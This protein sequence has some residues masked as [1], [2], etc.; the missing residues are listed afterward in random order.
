M[1]SNKKQKLFMSAYEHCH[2]PFM[3]YCSALAF[4]KMD[5]EDLV[6]DVLLSAY[7]HFNTIKDKDKLLHYLIRA[8]RNRSISII[9]KKKQK[10][11]WVEK[12][13]EHLVSKGVTP[14]VLLDIQLL[15]LALKKLPEEQANAVI[16]FEINGFSMKEIAQLQNT[17]VAAIKMKVSRGRK[18]LK[19]ILL[20]DVP[21]KNIN[22]LLTIVKSI[23]L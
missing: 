10:T 11:E 3:R 2:Q 5:V 6:Q 4:G 8:A 23:A 20:D 7:N 9:R 22:K 14:D 1:L 15:Y 17:T 12:H 21:T 19:R 16:L 18:R 13:K